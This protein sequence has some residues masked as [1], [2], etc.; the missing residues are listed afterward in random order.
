MRNKRY[1]VGLLGA[2]LFAFYSFSSFIGVKEGSEK[3]S[4]GRAHTGNASAVGP[5]ASTTCGGCHSGGDFTPTMSISVKDKSDNIVTSYISGEEYKLIFDIATVNSASGYGFQATTSD[6]SNNYAGDLTS[7]IT[8][9][10]R[11]VTLSNFEYFEHSQTNAGASYEVNW[12]APS[13][14]TGDVTIYAMGNAVNGNNGISGDQASPEKMFTLSEDVLSSVSD[15]KINQFEIYPNPVSETL[16]LKLNEQ[17]DV[18]I[19]DNEGNVYI[20]NLDLNEGVHNVNLS[21]LKSGI[22]LVVIS[23]ESGTQTEKMVIE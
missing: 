18:Q 17:S 2:S 11:L 16:N 19:M 1:L 13:E 20:E 8:S 14:G 5:N 21:D 15:V 22:Y 9:G 7:T 12:T 10:T 6:A 3:N 23:A 4:S